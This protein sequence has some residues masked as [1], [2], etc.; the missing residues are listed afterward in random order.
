M[1]IRTSFV[2][3][4][5][6]S[7]FIISANDFTKEQIETYIKKLL[8]ADNYIN[9]REKTLEG[10]C[11]VKFL[12]DPSAFWEQHYDYFCWDDNI[13]KEEFVKNQLSHY[14]DR[15]ANGLI[16]V[17]SVEDNSIPWGIQSALENLGI[18]HHWG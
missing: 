3:N 4:S 1:K 15:H 16:V 2:S 17:D 10:I 5:S 14:N 18:R 13:S 12:E 8:E 11:S 9:E 7:S 6:S